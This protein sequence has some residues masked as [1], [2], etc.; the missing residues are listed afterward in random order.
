MLVASSPCSHVHL[1]CYW[2]AWYSFSCGLR[3]TCAWAGISQKME[4]CTFLPFASDIVLALGLCYKWCPKSNYIFAAS[5]GCLRTAVLLIH[6]LLQTFPYLHC[7]HYSIKLEETS[8][9]ICLAFAVLRYIIFI[10]PVITLYLPTAQNESHLPHQLD[11][12]PQTPVSFP[13]LQ[14]GL[15]PSSPH[16][17]TLQRTWLSSL[18][19]SYFRWRSSGGNLMKRQRSSSEC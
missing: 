6:A 9:M 15:G 5:L 7:S 18:G 16:R 11:S 12:A 8:F 3:L 13:Q 14:Q 2:R 19:S 1:T 4:G 17:G 10:F